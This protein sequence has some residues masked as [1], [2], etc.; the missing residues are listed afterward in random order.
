[1]EELKERKD[2]QLP[3]SKRDNWSLYR[4]SDKLARN[5]H[6]LHKILHPTPLENVYGLQS[7]QISNW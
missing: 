6:N 3:P 2:E 1:M 5:R 7:S 4:D